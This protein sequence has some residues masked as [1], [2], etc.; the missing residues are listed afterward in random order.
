METRLP[1]EPGREADARV[2]LEA[3]SAAWDRAIVSNEADA[4]GRFMAEEWVIVSETGVTRREDFLA[5]VASGDLK[6]ETFKGDITAVRRYGDA[7]VVTG[8]V[9]N[10][11]HFQGRPFSADEWTT[12]VFVRRGGIWLCVHSH[13]TTV[14][15]T[16]TGA[17][18][19]HPTTPVRIPGPPAG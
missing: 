8:R 19:L 14:K 13:I 6:H 12:D 10:N 4:I 16:E 5:V 18:G 11:G 17:P 15:Q 1:D 9:R 2:E 7:A 3:L